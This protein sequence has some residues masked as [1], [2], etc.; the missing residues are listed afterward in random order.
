MPSPFSRT[1][2]SLNAESF[3]LSTTGLFIVAAVLGG[4]LWWFVAARVTLYETTGQAR[5]E[6][7]QEARPIEA[8]VSGRVVKTNL[9]LGRAVQAGEVL[10]ELEASAQRLQLAEEEA[11]SA[12]VSAQLAALRDQTTAEKQVQ[13]ETRQSVPVA[14]DESRAKYDEAVAVIRA[15]E[16]EAK[17]LAKLQAEGLVPEMDVIR[18]KAEAEKRRA[19][20]ESLRLAVNRQDKDLRAK[21]SGQQA[22]LENLNRDAA[23]LT[24]E[25][26]TRA[27]TSERLKHEIELRVVRAPAAGQLGETANLQPGQFVREGDK[28]GA[29][30]PDGKLRAIAEFQPESALGRIRNGQP[31][32]LRLDG[33]PWTEYGQL[34]ATVHSV[35]SEPRSGHVR[36]ELLVQ[37][38]SAPLIPLQHGLPGKVEVEV[39]KVSPAELVLRAVGRALMK[40]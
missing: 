34:R 17:R 18:A 23:V 39:E 19:A 38:E 22:V 32:R 29:I 37:P 8:A 40:R 14:L 9:K 26:K 6:V 7:D 1:T 15:A 4:W 12:A 35:A 13:S 36:V 25:I 28:L 2:R 31:A 5:L 3:R 10:V 24:G 20:A 16:E 33:F 21:D 11:R 30:V 27:A